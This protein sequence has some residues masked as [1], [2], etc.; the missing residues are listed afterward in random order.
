M[1]LSTLGKCATWLFLFTILRLSAFAQCAECTPDSNCGGATNFPAVCPEQAADATAGEYYEQVLTFYIPNTV[2]DPGSGFE[3]TII[4]VT[5]TSVSG[6]P[7]G[8]TYSLNDEDGVYYPSQGQN[9]GCATLCGTPL[10]LGTYSVQISVSAL[11]TALGFE[12]T[13]NET[14]PTTITVL[15]GESSAGSFS[16]DQPAGC[17]S[18]EVNFEATITAPS[19]AITSY[20]WDFGNGQTSILPNPS[21][22]IYDTEGEY[23]TSLTTTVSEYKLQMVN[24]QNVTSSGWMTDE[25]IIDQSPDPY[26]ILYNSAGSAVYTSGS[27]SNTSS[28]IWS[29][30]NLS[31]DNPPYTIQ[32]FDED[33]VSTDDNLG[34]A[35]ITIS[36]GEVNFNAGNG[37]LGVLTIALDTTTQITDEVTI[38]VFPMPDAEFTAIGNVLTCNDPN[39]YSYLWHRNGVMIPNAISSTYTMTEGGQYYCEAQNEFGCIS[40]SSSYLYCPAVAISYDVAAMELEVPN[41]YNSY[42]WSF[43]GLPIPGATTYYLFAEVAGD[44]AVQVTTS[45]G[46]NMTSEEYN[47][48]VGVQELA[49][50]SFKIYPNPVEDIL[51]IESH[52]VIDDQMIVISDIS[53]R[54][55]MEK[56]LTFRTNLVQ[57]ELN[58]LPA[59]VYILRFNNVLYRIIKR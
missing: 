15:P 5:I 13:Q 36:S 28:N 38:V 49:I 53:G 47:L 20:V 6:L 41:I 17:G 4:S 25:D 24:L 9:Y 26:F 2:T 22:I 52:G 58:T 27:A 37:T 56:H 40:T 8:L 10:L 18:V 43:N 29:G 50:V 33:P 35:N 32:F 16:Y 34:T 1:C 48:V 21:T 11:V 30:L 51:N 7:F 31:L 23:T 42:Q 57:I 55:V 19:P 44:Y 3:A 46:C 45:Y 39:L 54:K 59:A 14:F 12:L